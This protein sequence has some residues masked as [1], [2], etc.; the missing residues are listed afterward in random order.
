LTTR[1]NCTVPD[2]GGAGLTGFAIDF[3]HAADGCAPVTFTRARGTTT[4][5]TYTVSCSSPAITSCI[6]RDETLTIDG[7]ESGPYAINVSALLGPIRCWAGTDLLSVPA[8]ATLTRP[9]QLAPQH[10]PGC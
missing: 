2:Q 5:G 3:E 10:A 9:I 1:A 4:V 8:G 6:E 7:I